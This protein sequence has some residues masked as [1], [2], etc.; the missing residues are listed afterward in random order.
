MFN[1]AIGLYSARTALTDQWLYGGRKDPMWIQNYILNS[2]SYEHIF[3]FLCF[4]FFSGQAHYFYTKKLLDGWTF[5]K[6]PLKGYQI[7]AGLSLNQVDSHLTSLRRQAVGV[8]FY[9][10]PQWEY[11]GYR[12]KIGFLGGLG[13]KLALGAGM[14]ASN[15]FSEMIH[16]LKY[17]ESFKNCRDSTLN[18]ADKDK[19]CMLARAKLRDTLKNWGPEFV[20]LVMASIISHSVID[21]MVL[22]GGKARIKAGE[23][24]SSRLVRGLRWKVKQTIP[25][26]S[27]IKTGLTVA[28]VP[29]S[30]IVFGVSKAGGVVVK[31]LFGWV[32]TASQKM[33]EKGS[34]ATPLFKNIIARLSHLL[35]FFHVEEFITRPF[36]NVLKDDIKALDLSQTIEQMAEFYDV[37]WNTLN[38]KE[39][40]CNG[41]SGKCRYE[42]GVL[43]MA[44]VNASWHNWRYHKLQE[45][46]ITRSMW[47][48]YTNGV[49]GLV[50]Q[51]KTIYEQLSSP[52]SYVFS[53][54]SWFNGADQMQLTASLAAINTNIQ[55]YF[56]NQPDVVHT[57]ETLSLRLVSSE[58]GHFLKPGTVIPDQPDSYH[59]AVLKELFGVQ[60]SKKT[61]AGFYDDFYALQM[62]TKEELK[63]NRVFGR[64]TSQ[65]NTD[66]NSG[67][68]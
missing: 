26:G 23:V 67:G 60:D 54:Y 61:L 8:P 45:T 5:N 38:V 58:K 30:R 59:L 41:D 36:A 31:G 19:Y 4:V 39:N 40:S 44:R 18:G 25:T 33:A 29:G 12:A 1:T 49:I 21:G 50:D 65:S 42:Q 64:K 52:E 53:S 2:G 46:N 57:P 28:P 66:G 68:G 7:H 34:K 3:S 22:G 43:T 16:S 15:A 62:Q 63:K 17:R 37:K 13:G 11:R 20:S 35:G 47:E 55:A 10:R 56:E 14:F 27:L 24:V 32:K 9:S 6:G 51:T 48:Q